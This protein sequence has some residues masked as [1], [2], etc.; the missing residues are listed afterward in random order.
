MQVAG[1]GNLL[2]I[3]T[4]Y[5]VAFKAL[6]GSEPLGFSAVGGNLI[7]ITFVAECNLATI[8]RDA[9]VAHP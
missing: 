8:R 7:D 2:A 4:P 3:G 1:K 6:L 5:G 9:H